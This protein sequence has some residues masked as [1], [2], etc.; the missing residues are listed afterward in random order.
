MAKLLANAHAIIAVD[1]GLGHLAAALNVPTI[2][3]YGPTNPVLTG[4]LGQSQKHLIANFPCAPC[5]GRV[6]AYRDNQN[7]PVNP[8]CFSTL[9]PMR[10]WEELSALL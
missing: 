8:P 7:H 3:L 10:V 2:S 4:A 9:S 6:C 5:L 1:T